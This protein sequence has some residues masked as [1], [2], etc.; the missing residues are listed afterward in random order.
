MID[1]TITGL[2]NDIY[3]YKKSHK[4][5][6]QDEGAKAIIERYSK[7]GRL[8]ISGDSIIIT[9]NIPRNILEDYRGQRVVVIAS[10]HSYKDTNY[11]K[12]KQINLAN[13]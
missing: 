8:P 9:T 10:L 7:N 5:L 12:A 11:L 2:V 6:I 13:N 3:D 1:L 4:V